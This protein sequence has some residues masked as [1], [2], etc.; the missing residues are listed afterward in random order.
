MIAVDISKV[1]DALIG[2][3]SVTNNEANALCPM[4]EDITGKADNNP[5]WWIN[6]TTGQH[7]CF[8]CGY[9]GSLLQLVCDVQQFYLVTWGDKQEYD[10]TSAERWVSSVS[11]ISIEKLQAI[12]EN[13]P[14]YIQ[15]PPK[16]IEMSEA[17]LAVFSEPPEGPLEARKTDLEASTAY[18]VLWDS[19]RQL[20]IFPLR[21]PDTGKLLGWQEKGSKDRFFKNRPAGLTK[22]KTLFGVNQKNEELTVIV[23]SPLDCLRLHSAGITG[24]VAI[25]GSSISLEQIKLLRSSNKIIAAFDNDVA[26]KKA[27]KQILEYSRT[28]GLNLFFFNYGDSSEKDPGD[29]TDEQIRWG[30]ENAVSAL[31]GESAYVQGNPQAISS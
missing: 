19:K 9:K 26:G 14:Q 3:Y 30:I 8:S 16:P 25:C 13:L 11:E 31:Y 12:L 5:S 28:Y 1:L 10:Y 29:M 6:L 7:L 4:H 22:S 21:S 27:S 15:A 2:N 23:E 24:A 20:W 18:G 17:R